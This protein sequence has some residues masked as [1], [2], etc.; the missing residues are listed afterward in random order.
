MFKRAGFDTVDSRPDLNALEM[1]TA[2]CACNPPAP[3]TRNNSF[4]VAACRPVDFDASRF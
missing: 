3:G 4:A 1:H 2:P